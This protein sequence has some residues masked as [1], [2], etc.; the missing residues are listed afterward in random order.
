MISLDGVV[1]TPLKPHRDHR[2]VFT[3]AFRAQ[4]PT[5][6]VPVQWNVVAS[7]PN[8]MRGFHVHV[9]H[10]DYLLVFS[11]S[12]L[13][14]LKDMRTASPTFGHVEMTTLKPD[15]PAAIMIPP[16]V[17][18][19]FYFMEQSL[20]LYS[21]SEYWDLADE[22]ACKWNDPDIG[23]EWPTKNPLL[24]ERDTN[25]CSFAEMAESYRLAIARKEN[26]RS[27]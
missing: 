8:V 15:A 7:N 5:G 4:W 21:V 27:S 19:G 20:H 10:A 9:T 11:G 13:L 12:L 25:A 2:G 14:G 3:E 16:G 17:G 24:S 6:I 22:F 23:L 26:P 1:V 18:H